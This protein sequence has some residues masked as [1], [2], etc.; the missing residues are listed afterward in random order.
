MEW[1]MSDDVEISVVVPEVET[2]IETQDDSLIIGTFMGETKKC[3]QQLTEQME[4]TTEKLN[5]IS[6][7]LDSTDQLAT[8]A[9]SQSVN[10][11]LEA[12]EALEATE[13]Q[14]E[15]PEI[16]EEIEE[17]TLPNLEQE[18]DDSEAEHPKQRFHLW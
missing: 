11:S 14:L 18:A 3:L 6:S 1:E 15:Q 13:N 9:I 8:E 16:T 10:A 12:S 7:R 2:E 4:T 5:L 17:V